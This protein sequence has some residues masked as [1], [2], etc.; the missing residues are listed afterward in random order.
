MLLAE[1]AAATGAF[2]FRALAVPAIGRTLR[3]ATVGAAAGGRRVWRAE[4]DEY[5]I[6]FPGD[7]RNGDGGVA[8]GL[9]YDRGGAIIPGSVDGRGP[10]PSR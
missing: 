5:A 10:A 4:P 1:R 3:Y 9:N 6:G 8:I 2:D 7:L